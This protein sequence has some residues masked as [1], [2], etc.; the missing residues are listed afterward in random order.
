MR[1]GLRDSQESS[2]K[3]GE[4]SNKQA[5]LAAHIASG[6]T[7]YTRMCCIIR[8]NVYYKGMDS[9]EEVDLEYWK[10]KD[11][12]QECLPVAVW[13]HGRELPIVCQEPDQKTDEL[14]LS[15]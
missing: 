2:S 11:L 5:G 1:H 12:H 14:P 7:F 8:A 4:G 6:R 15:T 3:D 10:D 13:N 9:L